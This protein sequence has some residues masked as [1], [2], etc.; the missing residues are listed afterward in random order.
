MQFQKN[1]VEESREKSMQ[2]SKEKSQKESRKESQK[3]SL[4]SQDKPVEGFGEESQEEYWDRFLK[5]T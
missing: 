3:E 2:E 4:E 1:P 5:E